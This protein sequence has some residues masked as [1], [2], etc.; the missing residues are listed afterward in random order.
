MNPWRLCAIQ[1]VE[2]VKCLI[3]IIPIW[4]A[5]IISLISMTQQGT[6]TVSQALKMDRHLGPH[7]QIPAGST[8]VISFIT[9]G[10]WLP[11]YDRFRVPA[12]RKITKHEG[13]ITLLQRIGIGIVFS[14]LSMVVA[15]LIERV[16][17]ASAMLHLQP[18]TTTLRGCTNVSHMASTTALF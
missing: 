10:L 9:I 18:L 17:R 12:L 4:S 7:F 5:G 1:Q 3:R 8:G 2:E 11:F 15:G 14:I 6:F 16:R 13:G